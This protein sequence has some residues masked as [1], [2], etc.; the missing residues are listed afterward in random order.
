[1]K[2]ANHTLAYGLQVKALSHIHTI[3]Q[4]YMKGKGKEGRY[5]RILTQLEDLLKKS[6]DPL[7][8]MATVCAVL[9]H[10]MEHYFWTGFYLLKDG[11]LIVGPYQG[12][13]ACQVLEKNKGVCWAAVKK[14][15]PVIVPD[16]EQFPGHIACDSRSRSEITL[17]VYHSDGEIIAV[18]D[19]DAKELDQFSEVDRD[20]L[21]R[22]LA[23]IS[24]DLY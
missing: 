17:P 8:R 3:E 24:K 23:L 5:Q 12:P 6:K 10:K 20:Y 11:D 2:G 4:N 1:M 16:V 19:V 9:H 15:A 21:V 7:A 13:V 18:F 22:I 14:N